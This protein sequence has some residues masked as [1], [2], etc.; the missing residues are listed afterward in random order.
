MEEVE[1]EVGGNDARKCLASIIGFISILNISVGY[2]Y[3]TAGRNP[4]VILP[5]ILSC[6]P[7]SMK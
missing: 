4:I 1:D 3:E 5:T 6:N 2:G 7:G